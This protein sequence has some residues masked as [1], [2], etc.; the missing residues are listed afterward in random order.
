VDG[1]IDHRT[2]RAIDALARDCAST[3][4]HQPIDRHR[5]TIELASN[6]RPSTILV[7]RHSKQARSSSPNH[8]LTARELARQSAR[9]CEQ[10]QTRETDTSIIRRRPPTRRRT[11]ERT[12]RLSEDRHHSSSSS[13]CFLVVDGI[14]DRIQLSTLD[15]TRQRTTDQ[16]LDQCEQYACWSKRVRELEGQVLLV[17]STRQAQVPCSFSHMDA[18]DQDHESRLSRTI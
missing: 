15:T 7:L 11:R 18:H 6:H 3:P 16:S 4:T 12:R 10:Q 17:L 1:S 14:D 2:T 5:S 9:H 8:R 13:D